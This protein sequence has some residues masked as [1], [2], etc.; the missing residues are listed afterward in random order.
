MV[1]PAL[2]ALMRCLTAAPPCE[3]CGRSDSDRDPAVI[4]AAKTV[5][6]RAGFGPSATLT[7]DAA[8]S[9]QPWLRWLTNDE[10]ESLV[11]LQS[12]ANER[13]DAGIPAFAA[14]GIRRYVEMPA[15]K[16]VCI[17]ANTRE[18]NDIAEGHYVEVDEATAEQTEP[19]DDDNGGA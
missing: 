6:D 13:L 9:S 12:A 2:D 10:Y 14:G 3:T 5:L 11:A 19:V 1:E 15:E 16:T 8:S 4:N 7:V 18:P 17:P